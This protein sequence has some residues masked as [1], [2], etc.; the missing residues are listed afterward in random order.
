MPDR[1]VTGF[2]GSRL[3]QQGILLC[4]WG[5][6][7]SCSNP[8]VSRSADPS[9]NLGP[10]PACVKTLPAS[11]SKN[12]F[13]RQLPE[14]EYFGLVVP[15]W[16]KGPTSPEPET[17]ACNGE[18]I[19]KTELMEGASFDPTAFEEGKITYGGGANGL[20]IVWLRTHTTQG[21]DAVGP[22]SLVRLVD[23][24]A[25]VYGVTTYRGNPSTTRFDLERLG[26][27]V[28]VTAI[29]DGCKVAVAA[30]DCDTL[31]DVYRPVHGRLDRLTTIGLK[32]VRHTEGLEP[33]ISGLLE[34]SF[35][36]SPDYQGEG[37]FVIEEVSF[38]D[39]TGRKLRRAQLE[40]AY[41]LEGQGVVE[42]AESLWTRLYETRKGGVPKDTAPAPV[43]VGPETDA[44]PPSE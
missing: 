19:F 38:T 18:P 37:I 40:R 6:L 9:R 10:V 39:E 32:R 22:L 5:A 7:V 29:S 11:Q 35:S 8:S 30:G 14:E 26:G 28:A 25:E 44:E 3:T 36:S 2:S 27:E 1:V 17:L 33:G 13:S 24:H 42:T 34:V 23:D 43:G 16:Q 12:G 20:K 31:L 41:L 4:F 21:G 15:S